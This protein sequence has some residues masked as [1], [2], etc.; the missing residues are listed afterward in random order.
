MNIE[1]LKILF[2]FL[3]IA[4]SE[5][6]LGILRTLYLNKFFGVKLAKQISILPALLLCLIICYVYLPN[7]NINSKIG[8]IFLGIGLSSFMLI[9]DIIVGRFIMKMRWHKIFEDFN[10]LKGNYLSIGLIL[11]ALCPLFAF[12][13]RTQ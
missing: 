8:F 11:M 9:F 1:L 12:L 3:L 5:M 10:I 2:L 7:F 4:L 6:I 13:L